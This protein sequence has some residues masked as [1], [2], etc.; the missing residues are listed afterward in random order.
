MISKQ[1]L[2]YLIKDVICLGME[3][4]SIDYN[5]N[6]KSI[7]VKYVGNSYEEPLFSFKD[8]S[9]S[10]EDISFLDK[11]LN[12]ILKSENNFYGLRNTIKSLKIE[13]VSLLKIIHFF[14]SEKYL[15]HSFPYD[16]HG[17]VS[18]Y[19]VKIKYRKYLEIPIV[20]IL[21]ESFFIN[22]G[23]PFKKKL[24][25]FFTCD[26]D[27]LN[28][29]SELGR[30]GFIKRQLKSLT[31]FQFK[32]TYNEILS[33]SKGN[34]S[35]N[36]NYF[37][38]DN[39]FFYE[40]TSKIEI[41]NIAFWLM[42]KDHPLDCDNDF[43]SKGFK[44]FLKELENKNITFALHPNY[45]SSSNKVIFKQQIKKFKT[46][47]KF[48]PL[49]I[50]FH[51][52]N[53]RFPNAYEQ[54]ECLGIKEDFTYSFPDMIAFRGGRSKP[55]KLWNHREN[56]PYDVISWPLTIMDGTLYDYMKLDYTKA[57]EISKKI[58]LYSLALGNICDLLWH[59]RSLYK[60]GLKKNYH[61]QLINE[62]KSY[63]VEIDGKINN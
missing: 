38:N 7:E 47:F 34:K 28:F 5:I 24:K 29:W 31:T 11:I 54:L 43:S 60:Y 44:T 37:L 45:I 33:L 50:R 1:E 42:K 19:S 46:V 3:V 26:F 4:D 12:A 14:C 16:K 36:H 59:N 40:K 17:R 52:L 41:E 27:I 6:L 48:K 35:L 39:M 55:V 21:I 10:V 8:T 23:I 61:P 22:L 30:A 25:V 53:C 2:K 18:Y 15:D 9:L 49:K 56:K 63:I 13:N 51:Y 57:L 62:I 58:V 32:K 20:D